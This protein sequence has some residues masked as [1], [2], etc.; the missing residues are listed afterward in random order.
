MLLPGQCVP[1]GVEVVRDVLLVLSQLG[2]GLVWDV[3]AE[4]GPLWCP[5]LPHLPLQ[6][7]GDVEQHA[8]ADGGQQVDQ[9]SGQGEH[10]LELEVPVVQRPE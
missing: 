1:G 3:E 4:V 2:G 7:T 5:A 9:D 8:Q 6:H 10:G